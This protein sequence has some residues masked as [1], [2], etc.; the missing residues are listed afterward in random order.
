LFATRSAQAVPLLATVG[1]AGLV[2]FVWHF[3]AL[4]LLAGVV[5]AIG[6][7]RE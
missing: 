1:V 7:R 5:A 6:V 2:D 3:P 4:G